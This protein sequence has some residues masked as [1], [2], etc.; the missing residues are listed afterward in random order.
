L[1][2]EVFDLSSS[3]G[4]VGYGSGV[5]LGVGEWLDGTGIVWSR[6]LVAVDGHE[7]ITLE[8]G[9]GYQGC[10]DGNLLV[11]DSQSVSVGVGVGEQSAL[12]D[13]IS[14]WLDTRYQ[15]RW[16]EGRLLNLGKVVLWVLVQG[17]LS[18]WSERVFR[19]R[20]DLGKIK[21]RMSELLC[22]CL[23]HGLYADSP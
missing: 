6:S 13:G 17:D 11:V 23:G 14:T 2:Q 15:V 10:I 19:V 9:N 22:L 3:H 16:R 21:D 18:H 8:V 4:F 20:P 1:R 7:S 12:Q 5:S